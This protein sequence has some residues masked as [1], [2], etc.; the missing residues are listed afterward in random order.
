MNS[1]YII[2]AVHTRCYGDNFIIE[3]RPVDVADSKE[4]AIEEARRMMLNEGSNKKS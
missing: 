3:R 2:M 1:V 4:A